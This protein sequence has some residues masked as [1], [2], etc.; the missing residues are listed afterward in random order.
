MNLD[1]VELHITLIDC[2]A[3]LVLKYSLPWVSQS[4][5][6]SAK[7]KIADEMARGRLSR[8]P[9]HMVMNPMLSLTK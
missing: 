7:N 5:R 3:I 9:A 6:H 2:F 8:T 4:M 1:A